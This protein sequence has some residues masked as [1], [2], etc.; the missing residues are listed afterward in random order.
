MGRKQ[1]LR[2]QPRPGEPPVVSK[3]A[4]DRLPSNLPAI[5]ACCLLVILL[6]VFSYSNS[7]GNGFVWDDHAQIAMNPVLRSGAPLGQV[8]S[9][10]VWSFSSSSREAAAAG[11]NSIY[12]RPLQMVAYR[13]TA[14]IA[15]VNPGPFHVLS[16]G[17][18]GVAALLTLIIFW[19]L[20]HRLALA[21]AAAALFAVHPIHTEAVDWASALP[22]IGCTVF[23]LLGFFMFLLSAR[24]FSQ[25]DGPI[26]LSPK[27]VA[28]WTMS[29]TCFV[30][31]LLWKETAAVFP[32]LVAAYVLLVACDGSLASRSKAALMQ[33]L[34]YWLVLAGYF[35][36]RFGMLGLTRTSQRNWLLDP[37]QIGLTVS[38][39]LMKYWW[40]LIAPIPLNAY[41]VFSPVISFGSARAIAALA[42]LLLSTTAI[43]YWARRNTLLSFAAVWVF[44]TLLPVMD[45]YAV[46]RNVFAERYLFLPSVG[47]SL[48]LAIAALEAAKWIPERYRKVATAAAV[49]VVVPLCAFETNRR[50]HD[51]KDDA[52]LFARTLE[53][54]PGAPFVHNM[55]A[56]ALKEDASQGQ[57]AEQHYLE[58]LTLASA[59]SPPD[60]LQMA[61]ACE[62]L[63][64][65]YTAR[66]DFVRAVDFL[67]RVRLIDPAD[68]EVDGEQGLILMRAGRWDE[69]ATYLQRAVASSHENENVLNGLGILA[70]H[71]HQLDLAANYFQRALAIHTSRDSFRASLHNNLGSVYGEQGRYADTIEQLRSAI[72]IAPDDP[73]FRTNLATAYAASGRYNEA[74][75]EIRAVLKAAPDYQPAR[76]VMSRLEAR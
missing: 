54:S 51:W 5:A 76:E 21:T 62:G 44:L 25:Q 20:T 49:I 28:L 39:L 69:A 32:L 16:F 72:E 26:S 64:S 2:I 12:Y 70:Q 33:S 61:R 13:A 68:P 45:I 41:Y 6:V 7:I 1:K 4:N 37:L 8:F 38:H 35:L 15:G 27:G 9:S 58:A 63:A 14:A 74:R 46:G 52:T 3:R 67:N 59:E 36:F 50:N 48:F 23:L 11:H 75:A 56:D 53:N 47:F 18:M 10:D 60:R 43:V 71:S 31:A 19:Q 55:V 22:D 65:I 17:F 24:N 29:V 42:F 40:K 66:S 34:P 57:L 73:E 30:G